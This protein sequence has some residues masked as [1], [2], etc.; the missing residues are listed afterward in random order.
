MSGA[1]TNS[2]VQHRRARAR[3]SS[4]RRAEYI[5]CICDYRVV[6][7]IAAVASKEARHPGHP[8]AA[9]QRLQRPGLAGARI[10]L[11]RFNG[12]PFFIPSWT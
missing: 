6:A 9:S 4:G 7:R 2:I 8:S 5:T 10:Y 11:P 12:F 3:A 1:L